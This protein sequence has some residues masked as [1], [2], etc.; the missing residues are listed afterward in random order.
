MRMIEQKKQTINKRILYGIATMIL[1]VVEVLIA[2]F[3]NDSIIRPYIGDVLVVVVIYTFVRI[4][5]PERVVLLPL[6]I[7]VFAVGV[8]LLQL[9]NILDLLGLRDNGFFR[10]LLGSVFDIKDV[11]CYAVGCLILGGYEVIK[12]K[13]V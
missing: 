13:N 4:F 11:I 5:V 12:K 9:V 3:V 6:Y 10:V 7:F 8:E 2:L 1:L